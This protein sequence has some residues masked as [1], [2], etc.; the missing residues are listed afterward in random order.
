MRQL[1]A[2]LFLF[3]PSFA[4]ADSVV[5]VCGV[6]TGRTSG[7]FQ[8]QLVIA[9]DVEERVVSVNDA[10]IQGVTGGPLLGEMASE[11]SRRIVFTWTIPNVPSGTG[12]VASLIYRAT[13]FKADGKLQ[14][15][16]RP[17]SY[18]NSF[19]ATGSCKTE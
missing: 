12:Q 13:I 17:L 2:A 8:S 19:N 3:L 1:F 18:D 4:L 10:L 11:N 6:D 15:S 7:A 5:Y 16:M 14:I 9:H